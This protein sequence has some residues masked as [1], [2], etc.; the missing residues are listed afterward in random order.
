[1]GFQESASLVETKPFYPGL[2]NVQEMLESL[3]PLIRCLPRVLVPNVMDVGVARQD[4]PSFKPNAEHRFL[5]CCVLQSVGQIYHGEQIVSDN[6][7][8]LGF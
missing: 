6:A 2:N 3:K 7:N 1:M 4:T 8:M 5:E